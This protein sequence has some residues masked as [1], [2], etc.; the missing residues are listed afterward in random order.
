MVTTPLVV[1]RPMNG[2]VALGQTSRDPVNHS[3]PSGPSVIACKPW[4]SRGYDVITPSLV[5]RPI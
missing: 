4:L 2:S 5:I 3:A 1:M